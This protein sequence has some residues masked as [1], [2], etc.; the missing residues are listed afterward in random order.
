MKSLEMV[1]LLLLLA[2]FA[3]ASDRGDVAL[4]LVLVS[5]GW[6]GLLIVTEEIK[7]TK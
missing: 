2:V 3:T 1:L 5:I 7:L 6:F 4:G